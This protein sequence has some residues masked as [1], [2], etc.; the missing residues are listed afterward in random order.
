MIRIVNLI[1]FFLVVSA[2]PGCAWHAQVIKVL[3]GD[4]IVVRR[5][6]KTY[7]I[8]LYGIDAP[9]Y[10]QAYSNKAKQYTKRLTYRRTVS[11]STKDVDR[12]GR[13]VALVRCQGRL[14]NRE[15]VRNGLAWVY[16]KYCRIPSLCRELKKLERQ[17]RKQRRGLWKQKH[18][19]SP[20]EWKRRKRQAG[21]R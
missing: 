1:L 9:E 3:D 21:R 10:R 12:Y 6:G 8:R 7:E 19:V 11:L 14:V 5:G 16:P 15:L 18:P 13:L 4:S 20:W 2:T 17:A